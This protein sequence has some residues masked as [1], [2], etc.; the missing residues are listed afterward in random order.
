MTYIIDKMDVKIL[1]LLQKDGAVSM[2]FF[3]KELDCL[4]MRV[5]E[6][7]SEWGTQM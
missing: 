1:T 7:L 5:G 2:T 3:Q 4:V 6:E